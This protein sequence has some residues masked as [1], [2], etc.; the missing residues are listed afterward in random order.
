[1]KLFNNI[2]LKFSNW[3]KKS[4]VLFSHIAN[5]LILFQAIVIPSIASIGIETKFKMYLIGGVSIGVALIKFIQKLT[6]EQETIITTTNVI[7]SS[8]T[9]VSPQ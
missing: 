5:G 6:A 1:M 3:N 4:P 2:E 8:N 9:E 7:T